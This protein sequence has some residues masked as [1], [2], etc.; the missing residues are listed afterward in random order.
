[1]LL[2]GRRDEVVLATKF[3]HEDVDMGFGP[4]A[5]AKGGRAYVRR[6][7][8][9]SLRRLRTDHIDLYQLHTPD[10]VTPDRG[11]AGR[12]ARARRRGQGPLHRPLQLQRL[13][14]RRG[15]PRRRRARPDAVR[16]RAEPLV[17]ARPRDR[18]RA[19][20]GGRALRAS[21]CIP[22][23]PLAQGLLTG[24]VRSR[25]EIARGHPAARP[26]STWSPTSGSTGSRRSPSWPSELGRTCSTWPS[27][28]SPRRPAT[29]L[30]HRRSDQARAG[31]G[32]RRRRLVDADRRRARRHRRGRARRRR[33][34]QRWPAALGAALEG[35]DSPGRWY[36]S[37]GRCRKLAVLWSFMPGAALLRLARCTGGLGVRSA[38]S[39]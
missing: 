2:E 19:R 8:E 29:G 24:K 10:P 17:A 5:G 18:A 16:V 15:R 28:G 1:M 37:R 33:P 34:D 4:A 12:A 39:G 22:Y 32:E 20:A 35:R 23:F 25:D 27:A 14:A 6:A 9:A 30:G 36:V 3:G 26:A 31:L 38:A 21:A 13:A 7:V 11:D